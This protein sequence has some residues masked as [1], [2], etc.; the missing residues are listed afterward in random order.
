MKKL[1]RSTL[2]AAL[3][4]GGL[5]IS[6]NLTS[7]SGSLTLAAGSSSECTITTWIEPIDHERA[8]FCYIMACPNGMYGAC[9]PTN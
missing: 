8:N 9:V 1:L 2:L 7:K 4:L 5:A 6:S 3:L